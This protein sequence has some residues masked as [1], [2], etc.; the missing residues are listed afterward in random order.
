MAHLGIDTSLFRDVNNFAKHTAWLHA[1]MADY[2]KYGVGLFVVLIGMGAWLGWRAGSARVVA[3]SVWAGLGTLLAVAINQPIVNGI[4]EKRPYLSLHHVELLISRSA[5][6]GFPSDH[7]TMAGAVAMGL[8][9]ADRRLGIVT[10]C[11]ALLLAF[12][13]VYV[14]AHYPQ[15]VIAGLA[16]GALVVGLGWLVVKSP[17]EWLVARLVPRTRRSG[18]NEPALAHGGPGTSS[19]TGTSSPTG[20]S[21]ATGN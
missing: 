14:G 6:F 12:S 20:T 15:D 2:A 3:A 10:W 13:R 5:D 17:A 11:A 21:S 9:L 1:V 16:L 8:L 19:T 4:A 18:A 7:A